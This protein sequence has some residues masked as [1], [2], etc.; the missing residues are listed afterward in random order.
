[1]PN[2]GQP[3]TKLTSGQSLY[4]NQDEDRVSR[5]SPPRRKVS[6]EEKPVPVQKQQ[7]SEGEPSFTEDDISAL[8][9][10]KRPC[11]GSSIHL[12]T[13]FETLTL[14]QEEE[15]LIAAHRKEIEETMEIVREVSSRLCKYYF[16]YQKFVF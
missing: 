6:K 13:L 4:D 8:L 1:M 9:E 15:A 11:H 16:G 2:F 5:V 3:A 7:Q 12:S 10:V 14:V